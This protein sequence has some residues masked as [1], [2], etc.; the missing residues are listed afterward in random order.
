MRREKSEGES[1][2]AREGRQELTLLFL[3]DIIVITSPTDRPQI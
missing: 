3:E 1:K 2:R